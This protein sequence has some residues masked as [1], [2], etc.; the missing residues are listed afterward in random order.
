MIEPAVTTNKYMLFI[1]CMITTDI[2]YYNIYIYKPSLFLM[3]IV[4]ISYWGQ[5][6]YFEC[7]VT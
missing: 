5:I 2:T 1:F 6:K 7:Y 3:Y 4:L